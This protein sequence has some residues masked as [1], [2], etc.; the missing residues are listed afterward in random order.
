MLIIEIV[1]SAVPAF[2]K[3]MLEAVLLP[4]VALPAS[5]TAGLTTSCG[6][7]VAALAETLIC[8]A[9]APASPA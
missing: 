7:G 2:D 6:C 3:V 9:A 8:T 4:T 1:K 5:S